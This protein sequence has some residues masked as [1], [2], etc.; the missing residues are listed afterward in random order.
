MFT[1]VFTVTI[2]YGYC[3]LLKQPKAMLPPE[4][5]AMSLT[6]QGNKSATA[7]SRYLI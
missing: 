3:F 6:K 2:L 5:Y 7:K 1:V 4:S